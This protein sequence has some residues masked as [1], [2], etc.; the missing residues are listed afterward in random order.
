MNHLAELDALPCA[1][2][3]TDPGGAMLFINQWAQTAFGLT[4]AALPDR[5]EQLLPRAGQIFLQTHIL[6]MLRNEGV[7]KEIYLQVK[8]AAALQIPMLLNAQQGMFGDKACYRWV[9]LPAKHRAEF[10]Q[11][12]LK[13]R[14]QMQEFARAAESD[15]K[16]LQTVLD[17]VKDVGIL[18]LSAGGSIEFANIGA[19]LIFGAE[20]QA[21][22]KSR[23]TDWLS[24]PDDILHTLSLNAESNGNQLSAVQY[25]IETE[26]Q[27]NDGRH[28]AVQLQLRRLAP[29]QTLKS[30]SYIVIVTD[31]QQRKQYQALQDNFVANISHELRTPL[32]SILGALK[33]LKIDKNTIFTAQ[34]QKLLDLTVK[35]ADRLQQLIIDILDFSKLTA[36]KVSV[37]LQTKSLAVLL[38]QAI[39]EQLYYLPEK[40]IQIVLELPVPDVLVQTDPGRFLQIMSN[41]LS[42]AKKFSP[43]NSEIKIETEILAGFVKVSITDKGPGIA[44]SFI[45][46]LFSQFRQQDDSISREYEG[47]GLGLSICKQ[48]TE[49]MGGD[50]GYQKSEDGGATF[51]FTTVLAVLKNEG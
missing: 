3:V 39:D 44:D 28:I 43:A 13:N 1:V 48:L 15:R 30:L 41:L 49:L 6:P 12:L 34:S 45:P 46:L 2:I 37:Q 40:Q 14:Q 7:V 50:I 33:L 51:W 24:L 10:E 26:L 25:D 17:G 19:E 36:D 38:Q 47:T 22:T 11:Q 16:I 8:G 18:A 35:N 4:T 42:N 5:L 9:M 23:I 29:Q 20:A 27:Q 21:L 32:T 31:I